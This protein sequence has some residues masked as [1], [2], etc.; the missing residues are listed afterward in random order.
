MITTVEDYI[1]EMS[2]EISKILIKLEF[3]NEYYYLFPT[4]YNI[5]INDGI[6]SSIL[7]EKVFSLIKGKNY[8]SILQEYFPNEEILFEVIKTSIL[9]IIQKLNPTEDN[10]DSLYN[11]Y[12]HILKMVDLPLTDMSDNFKT[13]DRVYADSGIVKGN[14][15]IEK[16]IRLKLNKQVVFLKVVVEPGEDLY[17]NT[18]DV[19]MFLKN[20][21]IFSEDVSESA[22]GVR[23]VYLLSDRQYFSLNEIPYEKQKK[24]IFKRTFKRDEMLAGTARYCT[25]IPIVQVENLILSFDLLKVMISQQSFIDSSVE[26]VRGK[27][28]STIEYE[29]FFKYI[30]PIKSFNLISILQ[31]I[32]NDLLLKEVITKN[33]LFKDITGAAVDSLMKLKNL[34]DPKY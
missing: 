34:N 7:A 9:E 26:I 17:I 2:I 20:K 18:A 19:D 4:I 33:N 10:M 14:F 31:H 1:R 3:F 23:L 21:S 22:V 29:R 28:S 30:F 11:L 8:Y 27:L 5:N 32:N 24:M 13:T 16:F 12:P 6:S 15:F 25:P